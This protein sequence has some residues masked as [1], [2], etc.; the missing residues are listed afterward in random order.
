MNQLMSAFAVR[1]MG[2]AD[3]AVL[4]ECSPSSARS[5]MFELIDAGV[6]LP[7]QAAF[8]RRI[9]K[10]GYRLNP[11]KRAVDQYK[12]VLVDEDKHADVERERDPLV[13]ALFGER[14]AACAAT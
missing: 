1:E 13:A 2:H 8:G 7:T 3:A 11:D 12:A 9:A 10:P 6:I 14:L 4:L 5:Y